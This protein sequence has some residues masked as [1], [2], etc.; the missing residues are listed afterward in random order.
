MFYTIRKILKVLLFAIYQFFYFIYKRIDKE[1]DS[2]AEYLDGT[3][4]AFAYQK[5]DK[6]YVFKFQYM[7]EKIKL[8]LW[9]CTMILTYWV[10]VQLYNYYEA[11]KEVVITPTITPIKVE[12]IKDFTQTEKIANINF[13]RSLL[14]NHIA[15]WEGEYGWQKHDVGG[16][17]M[18]GVTI[19]TYNALCKDI[20]GFAPTKE[21]FLSLKKEDVNKFID[22]FMEIYRTDKLNSF[23]L[24]FILTEMYWGGSR[25]TVLLIGE[26]NKQYK[27]NFKFNKL[28]YNRLE[29][30]FLMWAN[31]LSVKEQNT[32]ANF[33]LNSF[34]SVRLSVAS[35]Y[36]SQVKFMAG[37]N[38]R[39]QKMKSFL[40][41]YE[42]HEVESDNEVVER[43]YSGWKYEE[44]LKINNI[45]EIKKGNKLIVKL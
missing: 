23:K 29:D 9:F 28:V 35:K 24:Q 4:L 36:K 39:F 26:V 8:S 5:N 25:G 7:K 30:D 20:Y 45:T 40:D 41:Y 21:H 32:L 38:N 19:G 37:W 16:E 31:G 12:K 13:T 15:E 22:K 18:R 2:I 3:K 44:I 14:Y 6:Q 34:I 1:L 11:S 42:L 33:L 27:K 10:G 17:T 43:K